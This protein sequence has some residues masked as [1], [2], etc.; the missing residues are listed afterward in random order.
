MRGV[1]IPALCLDLYEVLAEL[2][3]SCLSVV[4]LRSPHR[5]RSVVLLR[6]L[7]RHAHRRGVR[8]RLRLYAI[9][10]LLL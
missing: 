6:R 4:E 2:L 9:G 8:G 5:E 1:R 10:H 3:P 7:G